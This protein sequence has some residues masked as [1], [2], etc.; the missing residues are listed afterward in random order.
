MSVRATKV[1]DAA[2]DTIKS[3]YKYSLEVEFCFHPL[4]KLAD[5]YHGDYKEERHGAGIES[6]STINR[7]K[8]W[9]G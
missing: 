4:C 1:I 2:R 6:R 5:T 7:R 9:D 8:K 3:P